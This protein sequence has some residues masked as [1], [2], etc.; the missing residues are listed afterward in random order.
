MA[1]SKNSFQV[2]GTLI[3]KDKEKQV[4]DRFKMRNFVIKEDSA[5]YP[6]VLQMQLTQ[7]KCD[8]LDQFAIGDTV[9]VSLNIKGKQYNDKVTGEEKYFNILEA[10][11]IEGLGG[12]K[13]KEPAIKDN[14]DFTGQKS[15][16][17]KDQ[18]DSSLPF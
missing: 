5:E 13:A 6:Q 4:S 2:T 11:R 8:L 1:D 17:P 9:K 14:T 16:T 7:K 10:W 12:Y 18:E 3:V 15:I